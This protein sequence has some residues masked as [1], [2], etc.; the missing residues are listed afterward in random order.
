MDA[1][2]PPTGTPAARAGAGLTVRPLDGRAGV[3]VAG[4]IGLATRA[5][6]ES[7]LERVLHEGEDVYCLELSE[8]AFADVAGATALAVAAQ[9][10]DARR[11][12]VLHRPPAALRRTLEAFWPGLRAIEVTT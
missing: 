4:E 5:A 12:I 1:A 7:L 2:A 3:R 9:R 10:L 8:V 11:R 6:W